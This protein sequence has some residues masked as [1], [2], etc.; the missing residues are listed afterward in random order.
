MLPILRP[1]LALLIGQVVTVLTAFVQDKGPEVAGKVIEHVTVTAANKPWW[2]F[3][4]LGA[5]SLATFI[6]ARVLHK[7][8]PPGTLEPTPGIEE[9]PGGAELG[10]AAGAAAAAASKA[11]SAAAAAAKAAKP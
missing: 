4:A 10:Q 7:Q 8:P 2:S 6:A 5:G 9:P 3:L 11:T 1:Y